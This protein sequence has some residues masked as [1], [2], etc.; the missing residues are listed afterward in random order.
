MQIILLAM[1]TT[2]AAFCVWLTVRVVNRRERWAK[3]T[4]A[5]VVGMPVL[6][7]LS[8]GPALWLSD[9]L[10]PSVLSDEQS[11]DL[12]TVVDITFA[13]LEWLSE[14]SP[15]FSELY[16]SYISI[17]GYWR[18]ASGTPSGFTVPKGR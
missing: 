12:M 4:L 11:N 2:F 8:V 18:A 10:Y 16:A 7:F 9:R 5:A 1:A 17:W 13:P 3:W 6:Y 15:Q 14:W